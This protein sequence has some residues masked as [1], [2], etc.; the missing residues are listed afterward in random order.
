MSSLEYSVSEITTAMMRKFNVRGQAPILSHSGTE[1][2]VL[3]ALGAT[4]G[5]DYETRVFLIS[6]ILAEKFCLNEHLVI[7]AIESA[8]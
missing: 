5:V 4:E 8:T 3:N 6:E 2:S 7:E 1:H